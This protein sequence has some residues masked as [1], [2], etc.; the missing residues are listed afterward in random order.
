VEELDQQLVGLLTPGKKDRR[1]LI[2]LLQEAQQNFGYISNEAMLAIAGF[3]EIPG[4]TVYGI[5]TFYNQFRFTP[6]G[7]YPVKVCMGTACHLAGGRLVLEAMARELDT[8]VGGI[9]PDHEFSLDRVACVGCCAL[10][11][12]VV[13]GDSVYPR[14]T[15]PKVEEILVSIKPVSL[16]EAQNE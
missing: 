13:I 12:V 9:T 15:P 7:K 5:A 4:S 14:M 11:P 3:L 10:A 16:D 8:E 6:L 2:S 1:Y